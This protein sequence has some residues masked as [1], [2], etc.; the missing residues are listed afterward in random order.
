MPEVVQPH[1]AQAGGLAERDEAAGDV[2]RPQRGAVL[3]GEHQAVILVGGAPGLPV[4]VLPE[5]PLQ[6]RLDGAL[7][8]R[9][10][11][12]RR[13]R[14]GGGELEPAADVDDGLPDPRGAVGQVE[15][16]P[17]Q[18]ER[19]AAAQPGSG[20][21]LEQRAEPVGLDVPQEGHELAG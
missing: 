13:P 17:A 10:G 19:L 11:R 4:D 3:P 15:V 12:L 20:D 21:D 18:A 8:E 16:G 7:G 14:L 9:H 1:L 2:L 6:Q 5:P